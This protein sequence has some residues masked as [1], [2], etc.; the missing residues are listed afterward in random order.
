MCFSS[1]SIQHLDPSYR[2]GMDPFANQPILRPD[3]YK[4]VPNQ[5]GFSTGFQ[6]NGP[7]PAVSKFEVLKRFYGEKQKIIKNEPVPKLIDCALKRTVLKQAFA[8]FQAFSLAK[9]WILGLLSQ[10]FIFGKALNMGQF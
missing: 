7:G 8:V 1:I 2:Q 3:E 5:G 9:L 6:E 10:N 4:P